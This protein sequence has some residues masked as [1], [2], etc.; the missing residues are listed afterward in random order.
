MQLAMPV[1]PCQRTDLQSINIYRSAIV[2]R[3]FPRI[4][5]TDPPQHS[6][7]PRRFSGRGLPRIAVAD[8]RA[9]RFAQERGGDHFTSLL[10]V[11]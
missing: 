4:S 11:S 3:S 1:L 5:I 2:P 10:A 6:L 9:M 8:E 7:R